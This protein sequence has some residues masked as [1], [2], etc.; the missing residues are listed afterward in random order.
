MREN[1]DKNQ[2]LIKYYIKRIKVIIK[3]EYTGSQEKNTK[4]IYS[5]RKS[6]TKNM[7]NFFEAVFKEQ[8]NLHKT[9]EA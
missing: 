7:V 2:C 5:I 6:H 9:R 8:S 4:D 3:T 1:K